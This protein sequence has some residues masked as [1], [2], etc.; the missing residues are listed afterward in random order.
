MPTALGLPTSILSP[1]VLLGG[2]R[3]SSRAGNDEDSRSGGVSLGPEQSPDSA[4]QHGGETR[5]ASESMILEDM[6]TCG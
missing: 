3:I 5:A 4:N 2:K 1:V 6:N